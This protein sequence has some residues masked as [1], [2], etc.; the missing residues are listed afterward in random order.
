MNPL[1]ELDLRTAVS[2]NRL[3]CLWRISAGFRRRYL[4]AV[5]A[6]ALAAAARVASFDLLR[7][8]VDDVLP[9][10][11]A[12]RGALLV[13]LAFVGLAV[14]QGVLT[15]VSGRLAAETGEGVALRVRHFIYDHIQQLPFAYH[16]E[17][18]SG[19]LIQRATSDVDALRRLFSDQ[20]IG[21]GRITLL[22][23]VIFVALLQLNVKLACF[24]VIVIP[25]VL[26]ASILFFRTIGRSYEAFQAQ[27][28]LVTSR[29]RE[30][31][32]GVRVV[33]AF[34]RQEHEKQRFDAANAEW[35]RR[36]KR[37]ALL[38]ALYWP[39]TDILCGFQLVA[40]FTLGARMTI[41]GTITPGAYV[42]YAGLV[43][44]LIHPVRHLG[45][46][47]SQLSTGLVSLGRL[48]EIVRVE[49]EPL[50]DGPYV[51]AGERV[52]GDLEFRNVSFS[53]SDRGPAVSNIS[54]SVRAGQTVAFLGGTGSGKT[55]LVSLLMRFYEYGEGEILLD[56]VD[57][58]R[59]S[60]RFLRRHLGLVLQ[61]PFLFSRT[62]ADNLHYGAARK[63]SQ[64]ETERAARSASLH[65]EILSFPEGY[66]TLVGERGVTLS[67]GQKQRMTIARTLLQDPRILILDDALSSVDTETDASVRAALAARAGER[68]T[69]IIS[70]R[71]QSVMHADLILVL[72]GGRIVQRGTHEELS[73]APGIYR[74]I[75][76]LQTRIEE[77]LE[78]EL[79]AGASGRGD[80][81]APGAP[82]VRQPLA[83]S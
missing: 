41:A 13:A 53:Y 39:T 12:V 19:D 2:E 48:M 51:P 47:I 79:G 6:V 60:R 49:R 62:I 69:L 52:R 83:V 18:E 81:H 45:R 4:V 64:E 21:I 24:S 16:D 27:E 29:L 66:R 9:G 30:N 17:V 34:A 67:G 26:V 43:V 55:T 58:R 14:L 37:L 63:P 50:D 57:L 40:C 44:F 46:W 76:E 22:C 82:L 10:A 68:T 3:T 42:A 28:A 36:G 31:L 33:R 38:E 73:L 74:R 70:H 80:E 72:D 54:F 32:T 71:I 5:I 23:V 15:F 61:E 11:D 35:Y 25:V 59:Y 8:F 65:D 77:E 7:V 75:L 20:A 78:S 1:Q 56:G